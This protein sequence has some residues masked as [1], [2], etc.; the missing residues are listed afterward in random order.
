MHPVISPAHSFKGPVTAASHPAVMLAPP[1]F[2]LTSLWH[3]PPQP[4]QG[5]RRNATPAGPRAR[6]GNPVAP[7]PLRAPASHPAPCCMSA[8][9]CPRSRRLWAA[10]RSLVTRRLVRAGSGSHP[11]AG[12]GWQQTRNTLLGIKIAA[13]AVRSARTKYGAFEPGAPRKMP[14]FADPAPIERSPPVQKIHRLGEAPHRSRS[15]LWLEN[16]T[17]SP[18][19]MASGSWHGTQPT[20]S[21]SPGRSVL[22]PASGELPPRLGRAKRCRPTCSPPAAACSWTTPGPD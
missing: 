11:P 12:A 5:R 8:A 20:G 4:V 19:L 7:A 10:A 13:A 22:G 21:R 17:P 6:G 16:E 15:A 2:C 18:A 1:S 3:Q 14:F 9:Q